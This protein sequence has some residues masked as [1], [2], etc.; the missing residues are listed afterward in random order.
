MEGPGGIR[1]HDSRIENPNVWIPDAPRR[2]ALHME[3]CLEG[4]VGFEPTTPGLKVTVCVT[5]LLRHQIRI[6]G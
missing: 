3:A 2:P 4:P 1:A 6:S 5:Q